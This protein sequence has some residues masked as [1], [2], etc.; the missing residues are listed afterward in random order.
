MNRYDLL[1]LSDLVGR[2]GQQMRQDSERWFPRWHS[3]DLGMPLGIAYALGLAGEVGEVANLV[4]KVA[5]DGHAPVDG[6][7]LG[8]ELAD[9][10][11]YLLLLADEAGVDIVQ[12]YAH[13]RKVNEARWGDGA[14]AAAPRDIEPPRHPGRSES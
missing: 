5:R 7:G 11:T 12:E 14:C 10:L 9:C 4:K 2:L 3:P 13:K 6:E 1:A 8:A